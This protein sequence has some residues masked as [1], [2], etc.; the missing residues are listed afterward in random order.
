MSRSVF[1]IQEQN[2]VL[3]AITLMAE[4]RIGGILVLRN[5]T[6]VSIFTERDLIGKVLA[7]RLNPETETVG[8][9]ASG[10]LKFATADITEKN[11]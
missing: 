7:R 2:T 5:K 4:K 1:F 9:H 10:P 3:E 11:P 6:P 8:K